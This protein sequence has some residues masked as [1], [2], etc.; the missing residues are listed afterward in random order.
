MRKR[1]VSF[2]EERSVPKIKCQYPGKNEFKVKKTKKEGFSKK[3][4]V[5]RRE[6]KGNQ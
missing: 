3:G 4:Y 2:Q 5:R 1:E 6:R